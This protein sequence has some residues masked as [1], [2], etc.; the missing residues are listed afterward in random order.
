MKK[1]ILEVKK[2]I[3]SPLCKKIISY[4]DNNTYDAGTTG[5]GVNKKI[6][7]CK[8]RSI[9]DTNT[10]GEKLCST[11]TKQKIFDCVNFYKQ[12]HKINIKEI[13][14]L[15]LLKYVSNEYDVGYDFHTDYGTSCNERHLSISICLNNNFTGGE[16]VFDLPDG[17]YVVPQNEGDAVIFPSNFMFPHQVNKVTDGTRFA[18]IGWVY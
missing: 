17:K 18:V 8:T 11:A 2:V 4:F 6:R 7:N 13:S 9:L 1:Y 12:Q 16:F 10:F 3:P 14:Q 5:Q 15:D